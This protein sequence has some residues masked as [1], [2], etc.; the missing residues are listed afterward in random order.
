MGPPAD[1]NRDPNL[2][3]STVNQRVMNHSHHTNDA[4]TT[5]FHLPDDF[6]GPS[7]HAHNIIPQDICSR[8]APSPRGRGPARPAETRSMPSWTSNSAR[9]RRLQ[10]GQVGM[11]VH[12]TSRAIPGRAC[13]GADFHSLDLCLVVDDVFDPILGGPGTPATQL[14]TE[15][16]SAPLPLFPR[17]RA[18]N[19]R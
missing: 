9:H 5:T 8:V 6:M 19:V 14:A 13:R 10:P 1:P 17:V 16:D 18:Q 2:P 12:I 15:Q 11:G 4:T 7:S 3:K